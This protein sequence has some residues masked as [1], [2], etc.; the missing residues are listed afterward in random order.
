MLRSV[1][2][3]NRGEIACRVI[4]T[5]RRLGLRTIA[6]Y[7]DADARAMHVEAADEAW[8]IGPAPARES[9]LSIEKII[10]VARRAGAEAIHPGYGFLSE[11]AAFAEACAAADIVFVGPPPAAIR[12]MGSKSAAKAL[13]AE[14]GVPLVPGFHGAD[15]DPEMLAREAARIGFPVLIKASAGGGGKGMRIV[16]SADAFAE[17]L[18]GA[19]RE[20]KAAFGDDRVLVERYLTRARHVEVQVFGDS[21]GNV[22]HLFERDCSSQRRHQKVAEEAP[23]PG[24][25]AKRR[26]ALGAAAVAA[27]KAVGYVGAGTV[28]FVMDASSPKGEGEFYFMEMNT[29]L[30]VEH[31]VTEMITGLDLVEW[32]LRVA[33]GEPLPLSQDQIEPQGHAVEVRL[34]AEDP[35]KGFLPAPGTLAHLR[36]PD[37]DGRTL[38]VDTGVRTGDA[39]TVHYDP[40]IAKIAAWG[41]DR[42]AALRALA[43]GLAETEVGGTVTNLP[44]LRSLIAHPEFARSAVDTGFIARKLVTLLP[45]PPLAD[46]PVLALAALRVL[47]DRAQ[48]ATARARASGDPHSPWAA[49][50]GWRL[51]G[52][53]GTTLSFLDGGQGAARQIDVGVRYG[54]G[55]DG[56][57]AIRLELPGG[58]VAAAIEACEGDRLVARLDGVRREQRVLLRRDGDGQAV[59]VVGPQGTLRL[60]IWDP[61]AAADA[62]D[63]GR[64]RLAAPMPGKI[65]AVAV[66]P[67][68]RV[69]RGQA[70]LVM[71]AMK[72]EHTIAAPQDG[73][74]AA[75]PFAVGEQVEE[76]VR[77][78][79]LAEETPP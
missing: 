12:A 29:R 15:Q 28:E 25:P 45:P 52:E 30:Q 35:A 41:S 11:N 79:T 68:D 1:L 38:R 63:G 9:Y 66:K 71:E 62:A 50:D 7:S 8:P 14:A 18:A 16:E 77:L 44:F 61:L 74:I 6:V 60:G 78:V 17:A 31:P 2:I 47:A 26:A 58:S 76:G 10:A 56:G 37:A 42:Q 67:G 32:Q 33:S 75:V 21:R 43:Q 3:A 70:L 49:P 51:N 46:D 24:L 36:F 13:M 65:V 4:S 64:D 48:S 40:M 39:I 5:A 59:L 34:Y 19:Q 54:R 27:A 23:A 72:M 22:V 55:P 73:I 53:G 57:A 20:A 69:T